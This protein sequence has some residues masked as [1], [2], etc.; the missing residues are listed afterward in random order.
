[1]LFEIEVIDRMYQNLY[2]MTS[3]VRL[4]AAFRYRLISYT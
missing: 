1:V 2:I 3:G 4:S